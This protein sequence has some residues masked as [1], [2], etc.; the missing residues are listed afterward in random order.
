[1]P[2]PYLEAS[3]QRGYA[4]RGPTAPKRLCEIDQRDARV[5]RR[6]DLERLRLQQLARRIEHL[7]EWRVTRTVAKIGELERLREMIA[8]R[9][10]RGERLAVRAIRDQRVVRF[11]KRR[12]Y[13]LLIIDQRLVAP[14]GLGL[15]VRFDPLEIQQRLRQCGT[16]A[17][18]HGRSAE[19]IAQSGGLRAE[20]RRQRQ[21]REI[22]GTRDVDA[23]A[24]RG[25][26]RLALPDVG[27]TLQQPGR[28]PRRDLRNRRQL[29]VRAFARNDRREYFPRR[30]AHERREGGFEEAD[31]PL[32]GR[33]VRRDGRKLRLGLAQIELADDAALKSVP[34]QH[35]GVLAGPQR[36]AQQ[37]ELRVGGDER[38]VDSC[39][40]RDDDR[41]H[42][43]ARVFGRKQRALRS[44]R[45]ITILAPQI[46]L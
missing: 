29:L 13:G 28:Q 14:C 31:R 36:V 5:A 4:F 17:P 45:G 16:E 41:A 22:V 44:A 46:G 21:R 43:L 20:Q 26:L 33:D 9:S 8:S 7:E 10:L 37:Y 27:S 38:E 2:P 19:Q 12:L 15:H 32:R 11:A 1:M 39:D 30:A 35:D 3:A 23:Q 18:R 42:G 34:L 6:G 24:R 40:F 25:D